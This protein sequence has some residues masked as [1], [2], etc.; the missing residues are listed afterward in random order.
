MANDKSIPIPRKV[1]YSIGHTLNDLTAAVWFSYLI[2]YFY[3][4][5]NF[6][7]MLAGYLMLVGQVADAIF[8][9]LVGLGS[10][11]YK[12]FCIGKRQSWH[13]IGK[14]FFYIIIIDVVAE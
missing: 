7:S 9:P 12:G 13:V 1:G 4:V 8:T 2:A 11:R 3:N 10:D 6:D 5:R 14:I